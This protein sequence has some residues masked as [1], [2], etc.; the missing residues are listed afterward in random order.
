MNFVLK[1]GRDFANKEESRG[2]VSKQ[3]GGLRTQDMNES[4]CC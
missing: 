4:D 3:L 2:T 1:N